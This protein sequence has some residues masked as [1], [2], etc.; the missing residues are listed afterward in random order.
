MR[1]MAPRLLLSRRRRP[2]GRER[3]RKRE[4]RK[5]GRKK[6]DIERG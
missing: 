2:K 1:A 5:R 6:K 4:G 3:E